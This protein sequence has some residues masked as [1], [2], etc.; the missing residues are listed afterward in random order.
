MADKG[1]IDGTEVLI[2]GLVGAAQARIGLV[3]GTAAQAMALGAGASVAQLFIS[4]SVSNNAY[5]GW[6]EYLTAALYGFLGGAIAGPGKIPKGSIYF[7]E[8]DLWKAVQQVSLRQKLNIL[9]G[10]RSILSNLGAA[11]VANTPL[12]PAEA[13]DRG[14]LRTPRRRRGLHGGGGE[15]YR[16][17]MVPTYCVDGT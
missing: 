3:T 16:D 6:P 14:D 9:L 11:L 5:H 8:S 12:P 17:F 10:M 1:T 13:N 7:S 15:C 2:S 4:D